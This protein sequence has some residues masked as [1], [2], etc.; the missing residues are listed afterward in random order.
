MKQAG[1][2]VMF[3]HVYQSISRAKLYVIDFIILFF[4]NA[5]ENA[6]KT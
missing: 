4:G 5:A 3:F 6:R 1:T 2:P